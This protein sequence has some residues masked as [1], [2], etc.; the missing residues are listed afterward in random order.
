MENKKRIAP[1][2]S[3]SVDHALD[4]FGRLAREAAPEEI[5]Y[6]NALLPETRLAASARVDASGAR[7]EGP[8]MGFDAESA[9]PRKAHS[10]AGE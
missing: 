5:R 9:L 2:L 1:Y 10:P 3:D 8:R 4:A 6:F 7:D